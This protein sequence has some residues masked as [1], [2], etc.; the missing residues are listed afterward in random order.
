LFR[1]E[2]DFVLRRAL[3][4]ES[5]YIIYIYLLLSNST[6]SAIVETL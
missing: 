1:N 2:K 5:G 4:S 6:L 3:P